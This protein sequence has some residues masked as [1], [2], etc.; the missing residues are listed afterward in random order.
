MA[1]FTIQD[2]YPS[3]KEIP[4]E[5]ADC[6]NTAFEIDTDL[7]DEDAREL[8]LEVNAL[9]PTTVKRNLA[10]ATLELQKKHW[11]NWARLDFT[12]TLVGIAIDANF[13][14]TVKRFAKIHWLYYKDMRQGYSCCI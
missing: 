1:T 2:A 3:A 4:H 13:A 9:G 6:N 14:V 12:Y 5:N 10:D 11:N 7:S 8:L